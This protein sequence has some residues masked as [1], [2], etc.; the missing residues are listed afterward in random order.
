[1]R[2]TPQRAPLRYTERAFSRGV[3]EFSRR[4]VH[5]K[6]QAARASALLRNARA[7]ATRVRVCA[8]VFRSLTANDRIIALR[9]SS[10]RSSCAA[11]CARI[12]AS[13]FINRHT[14]RASSSVARDVAATLACARARPV[15]TQ[16]RGCAAS[17]ARV[18]ALS[19]LRSESFLLRVGTVPTRSATRHSQNQV[20]LCGG[21]RRVA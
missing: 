5:A 12:R 13:M 2:F 14:P 3:S 4:S 1:M 7:R 21:A 8:V 9:R 17:S 16:V 20:K 19:V 10:S 6:K 15:T 11:R 18:P